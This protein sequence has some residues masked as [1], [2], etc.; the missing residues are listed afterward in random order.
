MKDKYD[1]GKHKEKHGY[2]SGKHKSRGR[3][4][5]KKALKKRYCKTAKAQERPQRHRLRRH[6]FLF[7]RR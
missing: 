6:F 7:E 2:T 4:F 3:M 5:D 1:S